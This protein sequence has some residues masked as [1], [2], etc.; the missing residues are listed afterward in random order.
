LY[1]WGDNFLGKLG[2]TRP[3]GEANPTPTL[4]TGFE[5]GVTAIAAG[6]YYSLA[7]RDGAVYAWGANWGGVLGNGVAD[8]N[9]YND[10]APVKGLES[11]VTAI[12]AG[13]EHAMAIRDGGLY[14]WGSNYYGQLGDGTTDDRYEATVMKEF[15]TGVTA[16]AAGYYMCLVVQGG[17]VYAWG[18]NEFGQLGQGEE[19]EEF[20]SS[21]P[22]QVGEGL[23]MDIVEVAAGEYACYALGA[24]GRLWAW[25]RN[26]CLGLGFG[27]DEEEIYWEPTLVGEGFTSINLNHRTMLALG[28]PVPEPATMALL[29]TGAVGVLA[30]RR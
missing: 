1:S 28:A 4:V 24:D 19:Y 2:D 11:D 14:V 25:G 10:P 9:T 18:S 17:L 30:R 8:G 26:H 23:L 7:I 13:I 12:E 22:L 3:S 16:I 15:T 27:F 29:V 5:T 6:E 21:E 20:Y